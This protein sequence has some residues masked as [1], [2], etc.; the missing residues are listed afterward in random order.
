[1]AEA[2][3]G[4]YREAEQLFFDRA[5]LCQEM[6]NS[7]GVALSYAHLGRYI[8]FV[9]GQFNKAQSYCEQALKIAKEINVLDAAG[10]ALATLGLLACMEE[11]YVQAKHLCQQAADVN[12]LIDICDYAALG[13]SISAIGVEDYEAASQFLAKALNYVATKQNRVWMIGCLSVAAV[14]IAHQGQKERAVEL[15][16]LAF[17]HPFRASGWMAKWP[18]LNRRRASLKDDL[19]ADNYAAAW[20]RGKSLKLENT[21]TVLLAQFPFRQNNTNMEAASPVAHS[22][23][24]RE[25]EVLGLVAAGMSNQEIA[26]ELV[27][28]PGTVKWYISQIYEKLSVRSRT[29]AVARARELNVLP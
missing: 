3:L 21:I 26:Q 8:Y 28:T 19:G 20:V 16:A 15:L 1:V 4:H 11:E 6:G 23:T 14:L 22:L 10:W 7:H 27:I 9:P 24:R 17:T 2:E 25:L 29:Q 12:V 18:L 13:L 5:S